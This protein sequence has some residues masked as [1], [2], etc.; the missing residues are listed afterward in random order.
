MKGNILHYDIKE[1]IGLISGEDG[2]RYKLDINEWFSKTT[3]PKAGNKIDF[4]IKDNKAIEIYSI[5]S[6]YTNYGVINT[7]ETS[8]S[9]IISLFF[10]I[11][12][13]TLTWW[14]F[15]IP[16]IVAVISG[17]IAISEISKNRDNLIGI[18]LAR[19][20]LILGYIVIV[21]YFLCI[22]FFTGLIYDLN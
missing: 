19:A 22:L 7:K 6:K 21:I 2:N 14:L 8:T 15:A 4:Q 13:L 5:N 1:S 9:S 16:S 11:I 18:G 10:G 3:A 12:G 17:H 20:G